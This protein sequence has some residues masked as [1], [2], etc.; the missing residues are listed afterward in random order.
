MAP[1]IYRYSTNHD[2]GMAVDWFALG[3]TLHE[4]LTGRRPF[5]VHRI[6]SHKHDGHGDDLFLDFLYSSPPQ[7]ANVARLSTQCKDFV[8][9]LLV[10]TAAS[11]MGSDGGLVQLQQHS[12]MTNIDWDN[13]LAQKSVSPYT[14]K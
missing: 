4:L 10:P 13:L 9:A 5:E 8:R 6:Q 14:P 3:V 7:T 2:H 11:R 12:W 1:E